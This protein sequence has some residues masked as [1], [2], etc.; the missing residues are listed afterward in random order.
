MKKI[1]KLDENNCEKLSGPDAR[2][3]RCEFCLTKSRLFKGCE[4]CERTRI[5]DKRA[6][7]PWGIVGGDGEVEQEFTDEDVKEDPLKFLKLTSVRL[8]VEQEVPRLVITPPASYDPATCVTSAEKDKGKRKAKPAKLKTEQAERDAQRLGFHKQHGDC[9]C[10]DEDCRGYRSEPT[11]ITPALRSVLFPSPSAAVQSCAAEAGRGKVV[12]GD[13]KVPVLRLA[14]KVDRLMYRKGRDSRQWTPRVKSHA[15]YLSPTIS[16]TRYIL[17]ATV[18]LVGRVIKTKYERGGI[19]ACDLFDS[20]I[21]ETLAITKEVARA[22]RE[23]RTGQKA[24]ELWRMYYSF[25][26]KDHPCY[27]ALVEEAVR[28]M[29]DV[30]RA[31]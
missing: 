16:P 9:R 7:H 23:G 20:A 4:L 21:T 10:F 3:G 17:M 22:Y 11:Q 19:A 30:V 5:Y 24:E 13:A 8:Y 15:Q 31:S 2:C 29:A 26:D 27:K 14:Q 28:E 18:A 12:A 1:H 25:D 6:Y